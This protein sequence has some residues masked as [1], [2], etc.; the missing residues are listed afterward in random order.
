MAAF[1]LKYFLDDIGGQLVL[2]LYWVSRGVNCIPRAFWVFSKQTHST[3][4]TLSECSLN[5]EPS[6]TWVLPPHLAGLGICF[7][8]SWL[9]W[10]WQVLV[11]EWMLL[12]NSPMGIDLHLFLPLLQQHCLCICSFSLMVC[13]FPVLGQYLHGEPDLSTGTGGS[14][15]TSM[16]P[17]IPRESLLRPGSTKS[18]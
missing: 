17:N 3:P 9:Q 18:S 8:T 11:T 16:V 4:A 13:V 2:C 5:K 7:W 12:R 14:Y 15:S 6:S 1:R 10:Q